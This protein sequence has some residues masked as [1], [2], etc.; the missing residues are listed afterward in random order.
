ML[1]SIV[2]SKNPEK[3]YETLSTQLPSV[4]S[5]FRARLVTMDLIESR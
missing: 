5:L 2:K 4:I 1:H 3:D